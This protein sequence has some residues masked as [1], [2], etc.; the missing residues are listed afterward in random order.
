MKISPKVL[1]ALLKKFC[2]ALA[3]CFT[4]SLLAVPI[5]AIC[6]NSSYT[7]FTVPVPKMIWSC[8]CASN[9]PFTP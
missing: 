1:M 9:T 7:L 5:S 2:F 6:I 4:S 3:A 8:P